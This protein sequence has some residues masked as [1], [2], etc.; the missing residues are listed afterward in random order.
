MSDAELKEAIANTAIL[1]VAATDEAARLTANNQSGA[2]MFRQRADKMQQEM[3]RL[4][5]QYIANNKVH[6]NLPPQETDNAHQ[7]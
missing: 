3:M 6:T 7:S 1:H 4:A 2:A 5:R